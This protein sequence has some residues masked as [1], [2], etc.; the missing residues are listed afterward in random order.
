MLIESL[1]RNATDYPDQTAVI[2]EAGK[3]TYP[4]LAA[5]AAGVCQ[6]VTDATSCPRVAILLPPGAGYVAAFYG[7]LMAGRTVV[8][9]NY[10]LGAREIGHILADSEVDTLVTTEALLA[11]IAGAIPGADQMVAALKAR[12]L[13]LLDVTR[14]APAAP[15]T[16]T[17]AGLYNAAPG[18]MAVLMYTS[19]TTGLPKGVMLTYANLQSGVDACIDYARLEHRHRF[20]GLIPLFHSFG[21]TA[22]MLA[23]MQLAATTVYL[24]RFSPA[25]CLAAIREHGISLMFGVPSMFGAVG[26]LKDAA[27]PDFTPMYAMISGGEPLPAAIRELYRQRFGATIYEGYGL[28]ETAPVLSFNIPHAARPGSVGR[29][30]PGVSVRIAGEDGTPLPT[31]A[32]G[33]VQV[34]G[35]MVFG[36]YYKL[37]DATAAA[38]TLDGYF[39]TGDLGHV[40]ADGFLYI[41]GRLKDLIIVSGEKAHPREIEEVLARHPT[42]GEAAVVAR[43]DESRG[44]VPVAFVVPRDGHTVDAIALRAFC[45]DEHLVGWKVPRDIFV[46]PDLPR[47]P[48]GKVLKRELSRRVAEMTPPQ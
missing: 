24:A 9:I 28:T 22:L 14:I 43:K 20:L 17:S 42:V 34:K 12:G 48:T 40:D 21:M 4:Q 10:L 13:K 29:P 41:T 46:V 31:D 3:H 5:L 26:R 1:L 7:L 38:F 37:P 44:E 39:R 36:G 6:A 33:E 15:P 32:E 19:A 16:P 45:R 25:A 11:R 30:L 8:P 2:C 27:G 18:D 35:P 23:P 47:S